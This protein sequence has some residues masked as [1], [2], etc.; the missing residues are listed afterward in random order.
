[1]VRA[2]LKRSLGVTN[3]SNDSENENDEQ[4]DI[5]TRRQRT[6]SFASGGNTRPSSLRRSKPLADKGNTREG[7]AVSSTFGSITTATGRV[8]AKKYGFDAG[9]G[10]GS[11]IHRYAT[12]QHDLPAPNSQRPTRIPVKAN[13]ICRASGSVIRKLEPSPPQPAATP[14][15][16]G[17]VGIPAPSII[18]RDVEVAAALSDLETLPSIP[19]PPAS[20]PPPALKGRNN[21]L[22]EGAIKTKSHSRTLSPSTSSMQ[23][24]LAFPSKKALPSDKALP[25][26]VQRKHSS[27]E[28]VRTVSKGAKVPEHEDHDIVHLVASDC[29]LFVSFADSPHYEAWDMP[30]NAVIPCPV[31]IYIMTRD[32]T[33]WQGVALHLPTVSHLNIECATKATSSRFSAE[34]D[35]WTVQFQGAEVPTTNGKAP[36]SRIPTDGISVENRWERVLATPVVGKG[37]RENLAAHHGTPPPALPLNLSSPPDESL[38]APSHPVV[39]GRGFVMRIWVPIPTQLFLKKETRVFEIT[40]K[41]W[42]EPPAKGSPGVGADSA[43]TYLTSTTEM[44]VSHLRTEREMLTL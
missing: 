40:A 12:L 30:D 17:T 24:D 38:P 33:H 8:G 44:T 41:V 19:S 2:P 42:M 21:Q 32:P 31:Q 29:Q 27:K 3:S 28:H 11:S 39:P 36:P 25:V 16:K 7:H 6:L 35:K 15:L 4:A 37:C 1:M 26:R 13:S 23:V 14:P 9:I 22:P 43:S 34:Q 5:R 20:P 18:A 10:K